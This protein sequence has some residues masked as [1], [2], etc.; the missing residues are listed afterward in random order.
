M[1][2]KSV[3][4]R[5]AVDADARSYPGFLLHRSGLHIRK[6]RPK[7]PEKPGILTTGLNKNC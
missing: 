1:G 5:V 7:L 3:A 4:A 2:V 6:N